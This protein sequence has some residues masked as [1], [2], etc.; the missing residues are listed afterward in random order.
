V[1]REVQSLILN[2]KRHIR[3]SRSL[4]RRRAETRFTKESHCF[5]APKVLDEISDMERMA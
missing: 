5:K 3:Q 2:E 4:S 1:S